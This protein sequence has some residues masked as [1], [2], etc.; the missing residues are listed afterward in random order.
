MVREGGHRYPGN[1]YPEAIS[2]EDDEG[3]SDRDPHRFNHPRRH[4]RDR[5]SSQDRRE[6][7]GGH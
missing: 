4:P 1:G 6:R 3:F 2:I 5:C 7:R